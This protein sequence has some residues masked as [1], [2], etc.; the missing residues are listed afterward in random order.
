MQFILNVKLS[1]NTAGLSFI[2]S[3]LLIWCKLLIYLIPC[4]WKID[5]YEQFSLEGF[6]TA[7]ASNRVIPQQYFTANKLKRGGGG[8]L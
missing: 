5:N 2:H 3:D 7:G 6:K 4:N 8:I 1:E